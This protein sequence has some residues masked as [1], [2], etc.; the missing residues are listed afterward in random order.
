MASRGKNR[1]RGSRVTYKRVRVQTFRDLFRHSGWWE[2]FR[3]GD[4]GD[5]GN[6]RTPKRFDTWRVTLESEMKRASYDVLREAEEN[7]E[8]PPDKRGENS[9]A[10]NRKLASIAIQRTLEICGAKRDLKDGDVGLNILRV[11]LMYTWTV[12]KRSMKK[13]SEHRKEISWKEAASGRHC[14]AR[15]GQ[16]SGFTLENELTAEPMSSTADKWDLASQE[17]QFVERPE[18]VYS[19][20]WL[21]DMPYSLDN[22]THLYAPMAAIQ[23]LEASGQGR[24]EVVE[25][26]FSCWSKE[27]ESVVDLPD[28][29]SAK[30]DLRMEDLWLAC[31]RIEEDAS[32]AARLQRRP[33]PPSVLPDLQQPPQLGLHC[34]S[35]NGDASRNERIL[36]GEQLGRLWDEAYRACDRSAGGTPIMHVLLSDESSLVQALAESVTGFFEDSFFFA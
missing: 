33:V 20:D 13:R 36:D 35:I 8:E 12:V 15:Y 29:Y 6:D 17:G 2:A 3:A 30:R 26:Q 14:E 19:T 11:V 18:E 31:Q 1:G 22:P 4:W 28:S 7:D 9:H 21:V 16:P 32:N 10:S 5:Y 34:M 24:K 25:V 23:P 27:T